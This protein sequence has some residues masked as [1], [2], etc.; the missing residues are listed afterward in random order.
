MPFL[1]LQ[2]T[3]SS[4]I[5]TFQGLTSDLSD[6]YPFEM[7]TESIITVKTR[8]VLTLS[9][10][11]GLVRSIPLPS[12][13]GSLRSSVMVLTSCSSGSSLIVVIYLEGSGLNWCS[14]L[15]LDCSEGSS[16]ILRSQVLS[17]SSSYECLG[18]L[19]LLERTDM[20]LRLSMRYSKLTK[21]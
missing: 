9:S 20:V 14:S 7:G 6:H 18:W 1:S 13:I 17:R 21:Q 10:N 11:I 4:W 15:L 12:G 8:H 2:A 16:G 3:F 19:E 5:L